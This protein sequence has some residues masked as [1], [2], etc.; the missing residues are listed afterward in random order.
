MGTWLLGVMGLISER[1]GMDAVVGV[2]KGLIPSDEWLTDYFHTPPVCHRHRLGRLIFLLDARDIDEVQIS[3]FRAELRQ[4]CYGTVQFPPYSL[5]SLDPP[6][7]PRCSFGY[8][9]S[10]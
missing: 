10:L 7:T 6:M 8:S 3:S 1:V 9:P 2:E 5:I 4:S